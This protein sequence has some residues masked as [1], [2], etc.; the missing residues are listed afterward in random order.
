M[1]QT[2]GTRGWTLGAGRF[3]VRSLGEEFYRLKRRKPHPQRDVLG[4]P[5]NSRFWHPERFRENVSVITSP[6]RNDLCFAP[7]VSARLSRPRQS[8]ALAF[9]IEVDERF[10]GLDA[11]LASP[12][13]GNDFMML[14][15]DALAILAAV[16]E[17]SRFFLLYNR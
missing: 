15:P 17:Q 10:G 7:G 16:R 1:I 2:R 8:A 9:A 13:V 11:G 3:K 6:E 4:W 5:L 12:P 14:A